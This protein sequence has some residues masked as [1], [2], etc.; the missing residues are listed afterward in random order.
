MGSIIEW[1]RKRRQQRRQLH[2][3]L[4]EEGLLHQLHAQSDGLI[5]DD[6]LEKTRQDLLLRG[7]GWEH[8]NG[9]SNGA[10]PVPTEPARAPE[11][12]PSEAFLP[13]DFGPDR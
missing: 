1:F 7:T 6:A 9:H 8:E 11:L 13:P 5:G 12:N 2:E 10:E 4:A 3:S